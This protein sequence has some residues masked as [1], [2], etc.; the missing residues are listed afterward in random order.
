MGSGRQVVELPPELATEAMRLGFGKPWLR[1]RGG[2]G[3]AAPVI[4]GIGGSLIGLMQAPSTI[5]E[6]V[7]W[8]VMATQRDSK[9]LEVR[10]RRNG[11]VV[12][13]LGSSVDPDV[14]IEAL[15]KI[16]KDD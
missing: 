8:L 15:E 1:R 4:I 13:T 7:R 10:K 12:V 5:P 11:D 9:L 14:A 16:L 3:D 2:I 6:F